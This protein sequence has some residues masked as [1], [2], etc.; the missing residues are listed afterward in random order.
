MI[1]TTAPQSGQPNMTVED[2]IKKLTTK[3]ISLLLAMVFIVGTLVDAA[4]SAIIM[5]LFGIVHHFFLS[6]L[7]TDLFPYS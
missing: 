5:S 4:I 2:R 1:K 6:F 3:Q 7:H